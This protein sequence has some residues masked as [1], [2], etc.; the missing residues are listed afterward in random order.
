[1]IFYFA[2]DIFEAF[3]YQTHIA[4]PFDTENEENT[5]DEIDAPSRRSIKTN[6]AQQSLVPQLFLLS[7]KGKVKAVTEHLQYLLSNSCKFLVFAHHR[8][9]LDELDEFM[10]STKVSGFL[11]FYRSKNACNFLAAS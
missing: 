7:G 8:V 5:L 1:M 4:A 9:V 10:R 11:G 3:V 2:E 6:Y